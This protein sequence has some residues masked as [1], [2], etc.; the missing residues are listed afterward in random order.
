M[1]VFC[2]LCW[3]NGAQNKLS[4]SKKHFNRAPYVL[5]ASHS[6]QTV[7]QCRSTYTWT[8]NTPNIKNRN[9]LHDGTQSC[10][11]WNEIFKTC[12][13]D[14]IRVIWCD[15]FVMIILVISLASN[16]SRSSLVS[17][18]RITI[19]WQRYNGLHRPLII[20]NISKSLWAVSERCM[21]LSFAFFC[22]DVLWFRLH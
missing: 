13:G 19:Q 17:S 11:I 2:F 14:P 16:R 21:I 8:G 1:L 20:D 7:D 4:Q 15:R 22:F 6:K 18:L 10:E 12:K 3:E 5:S 9:A